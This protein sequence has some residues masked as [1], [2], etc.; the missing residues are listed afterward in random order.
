MTSCH[1]S[2]THLTLLFFSYSSVGHHSTSD[3]SSAYRSKQEVTSWQAKDSPITRFR[4]YLTSKNLWSDDVEKEFAADTRK[5]I[6]KA[7]SQAEKR[8]KPSIEGLFS[9]VY[10]VMPQHLVEQEKELKRLVKEY[11]EHYN[12]AAHAASSK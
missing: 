9:D 3:D 10:D 11:P 4:K 12:V 5:Q 1:L 2:C 7:F 6:L 8:L